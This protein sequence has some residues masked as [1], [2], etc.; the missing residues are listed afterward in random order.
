MS[1]EKQKPTW[2][3]NYT[4]VLRLHLDFFA[5]WNLPK[6]CFK[7]LTLFQSDYDAEQFFSDPVSFITAFSSKTSI[8]SM[9][10]DFYVKCIYILQKGCLCC[11]HCFQT[12][13]F[14]NPDLD[15]F[16]VFI[17]CLFVCLFVL[18][19][20][21]LLQKIT[22]LIFWTIYNFEFHI[23]KHPGKKRTRENS[24]AHSNNCHRQSQRTR[25]NIKS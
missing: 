2:T 22:Y 16:P 20:F 18:Y 25:K 9:F 5:K 13:W 3:E 1:T 19:P 23:C 15:I 24:S 12:R 21:P 11:W 10:Y 6:T 4:L 14:W 8:F 7:Y 17:L